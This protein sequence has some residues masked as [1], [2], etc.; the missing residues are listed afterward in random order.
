MDRSLA[1][2]TVRM[3]E[4]LIRVAE[5][6]ARL[7]FRDA[8][9][10]EVPTPAPTRRSRR[11]RRRDSRMSPRGGTGADRGRARGVCRRQPAGTQN[12]ITTAGISNAPPPGAAPV[13]P[14]LEYA[15]AAAGCEREPQGGC[16][17]PAQQAQATNVCSALA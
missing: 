5:A 2:T 4:S 11:S 9:V 13:P 16:R 12:Q 10:P 14:S 7:M 3:L 8:V 17:Q 15:H 6:H 1:R